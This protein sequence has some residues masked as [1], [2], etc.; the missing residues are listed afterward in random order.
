M[1]GMP[2]DGP[3]KRI[4]LTAL[5]AYSDACTPGNLHPECPF[6]VRTKEGYGC[7]DECLDLLAKLI[8]KIAGAEDEPVAE[9]SL[10]EAAFV[11]SCG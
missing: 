11:T 1:T 3:E 2:E 4:F 7:G 9:K 6:S 8:V 5:S 10:R